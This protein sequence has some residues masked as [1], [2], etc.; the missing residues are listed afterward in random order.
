MGSP[1]ATGR[2]VRFGTYCGVRQVIFPGGLHCPR[3]E[4]QKLC[5]LFSG[6]WDPFSLLHHHH[7]H[8]HHHLIFSLRVLVVIL[9]G[10]I[11]C[12]WSYCQY[13][14]WNQI[15]FPMSF[16]AHEVCGIVDLIKNPQSNKIWEHWVK[17]SLIVFSQPMQWDYTYKSQRGMPS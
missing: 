2:K 15:C 9:Y 13:R 5:F 3:K 16:V 11:S 4:R 1:R 17:Q 12:Y 6:P 8:H 14:E 7:C 10:H